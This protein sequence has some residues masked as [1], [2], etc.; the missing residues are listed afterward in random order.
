MLFRGL[1]G[2]WACANPTCAEIATEDRGGPTGAL[3]A[4]PRQNCPCGSQVYELHSCRSCGPSV[5]HEPTSDSRQ[6]QSIYG[7]IVA[8]HMRVI[9]GSLSQSRL[10][11]ISDGVFSVALTLLVLDIHV[12][13]ADAV[14][15]LTNLSN[16]FHISPFLCLAQQCLRPVLYRVVDFTS[17]DALRP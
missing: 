6:V 17:L 12:P 5:A 16:C 2:L 3:Y 13:D 10:E 8:V 9:L 1:P 4:E 11:A 7:R 14:N 15:L